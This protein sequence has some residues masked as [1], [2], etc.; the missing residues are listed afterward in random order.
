MS[1]NSTIDPFAFGDRR[2]RKPAP[3]YRRVEI[4]RLRVAAA[5]PPVTAD[6]A[7]HDVM[8]NADLFRVGRS[9]YLVA[10][11]SARVIGRLAEA[12]GATEDAEDLLGWQNQGSQAKLVLNAG[13][14]RESDNDCDAE[15]DD[16]GGD[17]LERRRTRPLRPRRAGQP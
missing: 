1:K 7:L 15:D 2:A 6:V 5:P 10:P 12:M 8:Q 11:V 17:P 4:R 9:T 16:P 3:R 13:G 14:D